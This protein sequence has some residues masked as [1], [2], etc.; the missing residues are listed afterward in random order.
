MINRAQVKWITGLAFV[1]NGDSNHSVVMDTKPEVGG[2]DTAVRPMEL[3]LLGLVGCTGMD[4]VSLL[5]KMRVDFDSFRVEVEAERA[6]EHPKVYKSMKLHYII[7]GDDIPEDKFKR[8]IELSQ[9]RYCPASAMLRKVAELTHS[10]T[11]AGRQG[12]SA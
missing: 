6:D 12:E 2:E 9:D 10:Y 1:G 7:E 8:A 3:I 4:V 5:K 11:I